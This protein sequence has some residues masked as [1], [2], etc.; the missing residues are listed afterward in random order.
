MKISDIRLA[1][2][3]VPLRVPFKTALRT[4]NSVEDVIV[5]IHTDSGLV[6]Y[7]EAPPTG[8]ITGDT[9]GAIVGALRDHIIPNL[10]GQPLDEFE[11][12][13]KRLQKSVVH[14]TSAKA[15][16]DIALYDLYGQMLGAPVYKLLGASRKQITTD[17]TIS[18]N[19]PEEM[20]IPP[21]IPPTSSAATPTVPYTNPTCVVLIA[22]PPDSMS[23]N[24]KGEE[25]FTNCDSPSL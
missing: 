15:A 20:A 25:S 14:N 22:K 16:A 2:I 10:I 11:P 23:S 9:T 5:E 8:A 6:G 17:I 19:P 24:R 4:V 21:R 7:G 18:V 13:M 3:S 12:L 1:K